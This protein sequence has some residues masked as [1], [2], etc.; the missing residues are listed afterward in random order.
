MKTTAEVL[1]AFEIAALKAGLARNTRKTYA[2]IIGEFV[3]MLK[4]GLK[5]VASPLDTALARNVIPLHKTA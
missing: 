5:T 1:A 4:A 3:D 2:P